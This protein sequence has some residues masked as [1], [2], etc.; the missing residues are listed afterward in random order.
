M[1]STAQQ[2]LAATVSQYPSQQAWAGG[3]NAQP[4]A[5]TMNQDPSAYPMSSST[6]GA[7]YSVGASSYPIQASYPA[8][9][10]NQAAMAQPMDATMPNQAGSDGGFYNGGVPT[11]AA[12]S[13]GG[14]TGGLVKLLNGRRLMQQEVG[15]PT[16]V[17]I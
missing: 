1:A 7:S 11:S 13:L 14:L 9:S 4:L 3:A 6:Q 5:A 10:G 12:Q 16:V 8:T 17:S 15:A 2:P